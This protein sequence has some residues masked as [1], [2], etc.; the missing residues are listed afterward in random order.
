MSEA[1]AHRAPV[2]QTD[3][4]TVVVD[5]DHFP[6]ATTR[7]EGVHVRVHHGWIVVTDDDTAYTVPRRRVQEVLER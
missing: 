4:A 1:A 6:N 2:W 5:G 3:D 7:Y